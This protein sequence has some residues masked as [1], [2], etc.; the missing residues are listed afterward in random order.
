MA[1]QT[2]E[3]YYNNLPRTQK[4]QFHEANVRGTY[5]SIACDYERLLDDLYIYSDI[6]K[7]FPKGFGNNTDKEI[8]AII[9]E[10]KTRKVSH[11]EM[12]KKYQ[13]SK[14]NMEVNFK[15]HFNDFSPHFTVI[16]SLIAYRNLMAHGY[17]RYD[18]PQVPGKIC[19]LFENNVKG[20]ITKHTI[21]V[22]L[23]LMQLSKYREGIMELVGLVL[24]LRKEIF[25]NRGHQT[26]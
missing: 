6:T 10:Y 20:K 7:I 3:E 12:G 15:N 22:K 19:I 13:T 23:F 4:F 18:I 17:T 26:T 16:E 2:F 1:K 14:D 9:N 25:G 5:L 21:N 11:L 24:A 8:I